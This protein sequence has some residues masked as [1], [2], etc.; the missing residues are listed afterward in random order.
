MEIEA[1]SQRSSIAV[2]R[3]CNSVLLLRTKMWAEMATRRPLERTSTNARMSTAS[4]VGRTV[5][6]PIGLRS[7]QKRGHN[8]VLIRQ[9]SELTDVCKLFASIVRKPITQDADDDIDVT[10]TNVFE[11]S[12]STDVAVMSIQSALSCKTEIPTVLN[13]NNDSGLPIISFV[14]TFAMFF[15]CSRSV[16][17]W[18]GQEEK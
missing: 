10:G 7:R 4:Y 17:L 15:T 11:G 5:T 1:W 14:S 12:H 9:G 2:I 18:R 8:Y 16:E 13:A 3:R 6:T